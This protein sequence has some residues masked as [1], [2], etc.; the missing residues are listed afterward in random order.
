MFQKLFCSTSKVPIWTRMIFRNTIKRSIMFYQLLLTQNVQISI[1][2]LSVKSIIMKIKEWYH[3]S[4]TSNI[5]AKTWSNCTCRGCFENVRTSRFQICPWF[6]KSTKICGSNRA[7]QNITDFF[8]LL[9]R[10]DCWQKS[11]IKLLTSELL[12]FNMWLFVSICSY[13]IWTFYD[14]YVLAQDNIN[15]DLHNIKTTNWH[16]HGPSNGLLEFLTEFWHNILE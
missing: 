13:L 12:L 16:H 5:S 14:V 2:F 9:Y 4:L 8:P 10:L 1:V 3:V 6:W 15:D 11:K 7:K